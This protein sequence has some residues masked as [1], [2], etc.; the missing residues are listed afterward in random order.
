VLHWGLTENQAQESG[1]KTLKYSISQGK[2]HVVIKVSGPSRNNEALMAKRLLSPHLQA[3][4]V[5]VT[6]DLAGLGRLDPAS[7]LGVLSGIRREINL[8]G[9]ELRLCALNRAARKYFTENRLDRIFRFVEEE[10]KNSKRGWSRDDE[11]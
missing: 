10:G 4:G 6:L 1:R 7:L 11:R 8:R 9:G 5:R 2:D 3:Q